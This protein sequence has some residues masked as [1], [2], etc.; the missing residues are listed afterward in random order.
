[1]IVNCTSAGKDPNPSRVKCSDGRFGG[2]SKLAVTVVHIENCKKCED[3]DP[4]NHD[5]PA[6]VPLNIRPVSRQF[7][8]EQKTLIAAR[9][10]VCAPCPN[11]RD[12][13]DTRQTR[14]FTVACECRKCDA[15]PV[16]G[17][18]C[19][20]NKWDHL[21][22]IPPPIRPVHVPGKASD[23]P[24][25]KPQGDN[26]ATKPPGVIS[27]ILISQHAPKDI[28]PFTGESPFAS[29]HVIN[30]PR[31]TDR[32][33]DFWDRWP[34]DWPYQTPEVFSAIDGS[35]IPQPAGWKVGS[36]GA[37]GCRASWMALVSSLPT[38]EKPVLIMEDD[39]LWLDHWRVPSVLAALPDDWQMC[40]FGCE[41]M[42]GSSPFAPGVVRNHGSDRTHCLVMHPRYFQQFIADMEHEPTH[43]DHAM[44]HIARQRQYY[45]ADPVIASQ[46]ANKSDIDDGH[47]HAR[48][49]DNR[50]PADENHRNFYNKLQARRTNPWKQTT[51]TVYCHIACMGNWQE[52]VTEQLRLLAHVGLSS[53]TACILGTDD[54]VEWVRTTASSLGVLLAVE[55]ASPDLTL[56]ELP[57]LQAVYRWAMA[58]PEPAAVLY[59]HTKGVSAPDDKNKIAWRRLMA[60]HVV[61]DWRENMNRLSVADAVGIDWQDS[62][63]F[64]HFAGNFWMARSDWLNTLSDPSEYRRRHPDDFQL[65][66][67]PW[68]RIFA[69]MWL[70]SLPFHHI[71]SLCCRNETLW[72]GQ[73]VFSHPS[74]V[75]GFQY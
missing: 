60:K 9:L 24:P 42:G 33:K 63:Q 13:T 45:T 19:P 48:S 50:V 43:V 71:E 22:D 61:A 37:V 11:N 29:V 31:R 23:R 65:A 39:C 41:P 56:Y 26:R 12:P 69:E 67:N 54:D 64:P 14:A 59:L 44:R 8:P 47:W 16:L 72:T 5:K 28:L 7:T 51:P 17:W 21:P 53:V 74:D 27:P 52:V 18:K 62:P 38:T 55:T 4:I 3:R 10:A 6:I 2:N 66:A 36:A 40:F 57:A 15:K 46:G 35:D 1:M 20:L 58:Q 25:G 34:K 75:P 68:K 73:A 32:L 30:L 70:G 49:W